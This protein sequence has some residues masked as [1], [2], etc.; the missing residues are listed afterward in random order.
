MS[1]AQMAQNQGMPEM[2]IRI[3]LD[4][5]LHTQLEDRAKGRGVS[6]NREIAERLEASFASEVMD[7][8][9]GP[10]G[11]LLELVTLA[12][13][14]AGHGALLASSLF[15]ETAAEWTD[16]SVAYEQA[17]R[18][19]NRVFDA[20]RPKGSASIDEPIAALVMQT[21]N[22]IL[23]EI[24]NNQPRARESARRTELL[25]QALGPELV[26]RLQT[27]LAK[28]GKENSK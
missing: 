18:A 15:V 26:K 28:K 14:T 2:Q 25:R 16:D 11:G 19:A 4:D 21:T 23:G 27:A 1:L 9:S 22:G 10:V 13:Q 24:A 6:V 17:V 20:L 12:A 3:R 7:K 5:D 8:P